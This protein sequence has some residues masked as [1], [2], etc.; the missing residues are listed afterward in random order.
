MIH[1]A[2]KIDATGCVY[3]GDMNFFISYIK[4]EKLL[5]KIIC[6]A[7]VVD[8]GM[9]NRLLDESKALIECVTPRYGLWLDNIKPIDPIPAKGKQGIWYY[10][11]K[12]VK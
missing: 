1:A 8:V 5:G 2:N 11:L 7:D 10:D 3:N 4:T 12:N 9:C 6:M